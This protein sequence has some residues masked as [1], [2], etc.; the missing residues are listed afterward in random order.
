MSH[1]SNSQPENGPHYW[2]I[3]IGLFLISII[4]GIIGFQCYFK[5]NHSPYT[6]FRSIYCSLALFAFEGGDL[7]GVIPWELHIARI[8]AP[9]TSISAFI[10]ALFG[11]FSEQWNRLK[12]SMKRDHVVIIGFGKKG[13]CIMDESISKGDEIIIIENDPLNPNLGYIK[14]PRCHL[15]K[16]DATHK[17]TLKRAK[18]SRAKAVYLMMGDD[19]QQINSCLHIYELIKESDRGISDPLYCVMH[20]QKQEFINT[21]RIH[22]L[23]Q[24]TC[25]A[26]VLNIFSIYENSA[27]ELFEDNPPDRFGISLQSEH[28]IQ[29][30]IFGFGQAGEALALQ[31]A[32][33]GHYLNGKK[34]QVLIIDRMAKEKVPDFM[35]RYPTYTEYCGLQYLSLDANTPQLIHHLEKYLKDPFAYTTIVLC[36]DNKTQNMLLGL[37]LETLDLNETGESPQVFVRTN[38]NVSFASFSQTIK[39]Y[40]LPSKVCSQEVIAEGD[41][42]RKSRAIHNDYLKKRKNASGFGSRAADVNWERLSQEYKDSNR[43]AADH[44]GV[45][46]RG[47]GCEIVNSDDPRPSAI[48]SIEEIERLSE[49]EHQRWNAERSLAGW[50]FDEQKNDKTRKTPYLTDWDKLNEDIKEY[51]RDAVRNIPSVLEL[52]GMKAIRQKEQQS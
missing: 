22:N 8:S 37:Q 7:S 41:L 4:L 33:T 3:L 52:I 15:L 23:M 43:K 21:L 24:D 45:K 49:L 19:T 46:M 2:L 11:I 34:P 25:D 18:I 12:I 26:F 32:L 27:R 40:G 44:I 47:I 9:L 50:T 35:E 5:L 30:I 28:Y 17:N 10:I 31:T 20:L 39:P 48:F 51:D 16:A 42:D 1:N 13:K 6:I 36:F 29:M 14:P 38:D